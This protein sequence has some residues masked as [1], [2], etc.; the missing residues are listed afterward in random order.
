VLIKYTFVMSTK[1][2]FYGEVILYN[3]N[4]NKKF[5][6]LPISFKN[7]LISYIL[8]KLIFFQVILHYFK[9]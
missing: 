2:I 9:Y 7:Y 4:V 5:L 1:Q 8:T 6:K 3:E